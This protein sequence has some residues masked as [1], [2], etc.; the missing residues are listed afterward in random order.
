MIE[1]PQ[2]VVAE[3]VGIGGHHHP[4]LAVAHGGQQAGA[5]G[6]GRVGG[7]QHDRAGA[8]GQ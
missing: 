4:A 2:G 1:L 5:G 3:Q 7:P 6:M 8:L